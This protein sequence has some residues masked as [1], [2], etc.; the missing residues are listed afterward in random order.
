MGW[1]LLKRR[2]KVGGRFMVLGDAVIGFCVLISAADPGPLDRFP[3]VLGARLEPD[4]CP[5]WLKACRS[6]AP[7]ER[8]S[9]GPRRGYLYK[10]PFVE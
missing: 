9:S 10:R 7:N 8:Q 1:N 4:G 5:R 2:E 6:P 3:V